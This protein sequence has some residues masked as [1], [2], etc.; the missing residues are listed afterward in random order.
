MHAY[1]PIH[2]YIFFHRPTDG[3]SM[4]Q[5]YKYFEVDKID[6]GPSFGELFSNPM[7][8]MCMFSPFCD[9]WDIRMDPPQQLMYDMGRGT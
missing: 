9:S 1:I 2:I 5:F 7:H 6:K 8:A 4:Q 3:D